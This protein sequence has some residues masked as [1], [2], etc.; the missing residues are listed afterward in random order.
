[1]ELRTITEPSADDQQAE[2]YNT[3]MRRSNV[4][5]LVPGRK[6][7]VVLIKLAAAVNQPGD[8]AVLKTNIEAVLGVQDIKL[9]I[10]GQ[11]PASIPD[12]KELRMVVAAH[13]RIDNA[14]EA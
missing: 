2:L 14:P 10:D 5:T 4:E 1:M 12:G 6:Y 9:L 13:L 7:A 3:R 8:Y 11:A